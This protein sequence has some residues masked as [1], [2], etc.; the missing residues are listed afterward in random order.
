MITF[1]ALHLSA[2]LAFISVEAVLVAVFRLASLARNGEG[3][4]NGSEASL[5][6]G[7]VRA[8][9]LL[10]FAVYL[11]GASMREAVVLIAGIQTWGD[12]AILWSSGSRCLQIIGA[13]MFVAAATYRRCGHWVWGTVL[14]AAVLFSMVAA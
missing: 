11:I 1:I 10:S 6:I 4:G 5:P 12:T 2:I 13:C 7:N 9:V 8:W 14:A 3:N